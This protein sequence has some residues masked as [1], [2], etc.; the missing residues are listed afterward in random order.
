M[1]WSLVYL[2][3]ELLLVPD[4]ANSGESDDWHSTSVVLLI[5]MSISLEEFVNIGE[6]VH[7][8]SDCRKGID[9]AIAGLE[10]CGGGAVALLRSDV[11]LIG[12]SISAASESSCFEADKPLPSPFYIFVRCFVTK[13]SRN[14]SI[15]SHRASLLINLYILWVLYGRY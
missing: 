8:R 11:A 12:D 4:H 3:S 9:I 14:P 1:H 13:H 2:R 15:T 7:T 6:V 10:L 5:N